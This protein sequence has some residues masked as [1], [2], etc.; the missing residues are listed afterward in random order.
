M[1]PTGPDHTGAYGSPGGLWV[2]LQS[3]P[4][5]QGQWETLKDLKEVG[6]SQSDLHLNKH[7]D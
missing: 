4:L 2:M 6:L 5:S 7:M 1:K 3:L